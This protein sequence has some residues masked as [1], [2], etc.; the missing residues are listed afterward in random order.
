MRNIEKYYKNTESKKTRNNVEYFVNNIKCRSGKAIELGCGAGNDT[1]F[2]IKNNWIVLAIDKEDVKERIAKRL[3]NE[4][5][6]KFRFQKQNFESLKLE[7]NNLI[8]ANYSL[9][10]CN[11]NNFKELWNKINDSLLKDGY[12]V[13]NFFGNNDEWKSTKQEMTFLTKRQVIELFK[14]FE[15][16][17]FKEFEKDDFTA[18]GKMKHWHI[19]DVI[20]KKN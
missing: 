5:R 7:K 9:S 15:I 17:K 13:G 16:I 10:F 8:L 14:N 19:F 12:F 18:L 20:A 3:N 4:E 2:L 1:V 6:E 11:K